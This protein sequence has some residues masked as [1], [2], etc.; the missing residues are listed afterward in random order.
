[1]G[2]LLVTCNEVFENAEFGAALLV[3]RRVEIIFV[4]T[5]R[6]CLSCM[7]GNELGQK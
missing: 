2:W 4:V 5:T 1:M 7:H 6:L 3:V